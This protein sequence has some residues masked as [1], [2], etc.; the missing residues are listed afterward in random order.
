MQPYATAPPRRPGLFRRLLD[1]L[2]GFRRLVLNLLFLLL[3]VVLLF[4]IF[5][6]SSHPVVPD[7][8]A[9]VLDVSGDLVEQ[10]SPAE[11]LATVLD[12]GLTSETVLQ[13]AVDAVDAAAKDERI[14]SIVLQLDGMGAA[15]IPKLTAIGEALTRFRAAGKKIYAVGDSYTQAQ[16][17]L[18]SFADRIYM[19]PYGDVT[20]T[21][22]SAYD[23]FMRE[24]LEK[25]SV[26]MNVFRVGQFKAAV[27]PFLRNDMSPE[28]EA[29]NKALIDSQWQ[30]YRTRVAANRKL[31]PADIEGYLQGY[32]ALVQ[33]NRG[34][35]ARVAVERRLVD[36][37]LTRDA[38]RARL[39]E[40]VG[41]D[42]EESFLRIDLHDYTRAIAPTLPGSDGAQVGVVTVRGT[43][44]V[45]DPRGGSA[46][47]NQIVQLL[48][49]A[50]ADDNV[51]A[52]VLR[53]DSP[54]GSAFGSELIRA[55]VELL[56][57]A[58]KPVVV[59]MSGLA[60]SGG[61]WI[62]ATSDEIWADPSTI[63]GSIGIFGLVPTFETSLA[64]IGVR[65]DGVANA[66]LGAGAGPFSALPPD[67]ALVLQSTVEHG[68]RQFVNLVARGRS[69]KPEQVEAIAQGRVWTGSDA[70][71][72]GLV[73]QLGGLDGA[74]AAA[75]KRAKLEQWTVR[76]IEPEQD[77]R[78]AL[79]LSLA[80]EFGFADTASARQGS[81]MRTVID[82]LLGS[83]ELLSRLDDPRH[84]YTL[85]TGCRMG[86]A[87][88]P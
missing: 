61:Y 51:K 31:K 44:V 2:D 40:L 27:E 66:P 20:L 88:G 41:Q 75:A 15:D 22:F 67:V 80:E 83:T 8:A 25:L 60:A 38:M 10:R 3:L 52:L 18:A 86:P 12:G 24:A 7:G 79:L 32:A 70:K 26:H 21:G 23:L 50:R 74:V 82:G 4:A 16:Y 49:D 53:V 71:R 9:L 19:H 28:A 1:L 54:G 46:G 11:A 34:D 81:A 64:Q 76:R 55:E 36:E 78:Q 59:S 56:Q 29:A 33:A 65:A 14:A 17:F 87:G 35:L 48:R 73:D 58:G 42:D 43:I 37:L 6:P 85:C 5:G 13:D 57:L 63:T 30:N 68:Y 47:A 77:A 62:A 69:M 84:L 39:R 45:D 72:L